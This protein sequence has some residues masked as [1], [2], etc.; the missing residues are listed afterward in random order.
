M[1][2]WVTHSEAVDILGGPPFCLPPPGSLAS[3]GGGWNSLPFS[4]HLPSQESSFNNWEPSLMSSRL[5][6]S[7]RLILSPPPLLFFF[8]SIFSISRKCAPSVQ[9]L[10]YLVPERTR[11]AWTLAELNDPRRKAWGLIVHGLQIP[12]LPEE[13]PRLVPPD[14]FVPYTPAE[15]SAHVPRYPWS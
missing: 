9:V 14:G 3:R 1:A 8:K 5:P 4:A 6:V 10:V 12:P 15:S 7:C 2:T 13:V 11:Y